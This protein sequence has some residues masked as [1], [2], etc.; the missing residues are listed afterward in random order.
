[1]KK[2]LI[3]VLSVFTFFG[4]EE[5][6]TDNIVISLLGAPVVYVPVN[7]D[8]SEPGFIA[9]SSVDGDV[10]A[11]VTVD[12]SKVDTSVPG[13]YTVGYQIRNRLGE[14]VS[15]SRIVK[16]TETTA[17]LRLEGDSL[18]TVELLETFND[19]GLTVVDVD[20]S[21]ALSKVTVQS[22]Y[23]NEVPGSYAIIYSFTDLLGVTHSATR[24]VN[25]VIP[26]EPIIILKG[27]GKTADNPLRLGQA[28]KLEDFFAA[29]RKLDPGWTAYSRRYG[30]VSAFVTADYSQIN[31]ENVNLTPQ[32]AVYTLTIG[33]GEEAQ[34]AT[35]SRYVVI[36]DDALPP[37]ITLYTDVRSSIAADASATFATLEE[38]EED[39]DA[40]DDTSATVI[41]TVEVFSVDSLTN[42]T[43]QDPV[44][45]TDL[46]NILHN[47]GFYKVVYS[48]A[49]D[50]GNTASVERLIEVYDATKPVLTVTLPQEVAA[51]E[52]GETTQIEWRPVALTSDFSFL[53]EVEYA[54]AKTQ[55][56]SD[57]TASDESSS[58]NI[59]KIEKTQTND[60]N[61]RV[62]GTY[63]TVF[64][65]RDDAGNISYR[66]TRIVRILPPP[67][68]VVQNYSFED[69]SP[70]IGELDKD[71]NQIIGWQ[72]ENVRAYKVAGTYS[73]WG[74]VY[75]GVGPYA[76]SDRFASVNF[77]EASASKGTVGYSSA[78]LCGVIRTAEEEKDPIIGAIILNAAH[79][80]TRTMGAI[81]QKKIFVYADV[82]YKLNV[83]FMY[84]IDASSQDIEFVISRSDASPSLKLTG[85][86]YKSDGTEQNVNNGTQISRYISTRSLNRENSWNLVELEFTPSQDGYIDLRFTK[87]DI[88]SGADRDG[89]GTWIDNVR[90]I[91]VKY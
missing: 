83:D 30:D 33:E 76:Y 84:Q 50:A 59:L 22:D 2:F 41:K 65:A 11:R 9:N 55:L 60:I 35:A 16:V 54:S 58:R 80:Y 53:Q 14:T 24:T 32:T 12:D 17:F 57:V 61:M 46:P 4:C 49:D 28:K 51:G 15:A 29:S 90:I 38:M 87:T 86:T 39:F 78:F 75:T 34:T 21:D 45:E 44:S 81:T 91:P 43:R 89:T 64:Y 36:V 42:P 73:Q 1:M 37:E 67:Q 69:Y 79:Y 6:R 48:A 66:F 71:T 20:G 72:F 13:T 3:L 88:G 68:P 82:T 85:K 70:A 8:Y 10:S 27:A 23:T 74:E 77:A 19:P 52:D 26:E 56:V 40:E 5:Q 18:I 63:E 47:I 31:F 25:V 7:G 62:P